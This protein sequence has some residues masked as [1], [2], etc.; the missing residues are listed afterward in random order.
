[1]LPGVSWDKKA[2]DKS[3][4][5]EIDRLN[6]Y[7][8]AQ[9]PYLG[10]DHGLAFDQYFKVFGVWATDSEFNSSV[11]AIQA[12]WEPVYFP[13]AMGAAHALFDEKIRLRIRPYLY[14]EYGVPTG[15]GDSTQLEG[16]PAFLRFGPAL[17]ITLWP[18][19]Y[20][21]AS[22]SLKRLTLVGE[23]KYRWG[24]MGD[25]GSTDYFEAGIDYPLENFR[26]VSIVLKY[27]SGKNDITADKVDQLVL[28]LGLR[29]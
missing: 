16:S 22:P 17:Q 29:F 2:D 14:S 10:R 3:P 25:P 27:T 20:L 9:V 19:E 21:G 5:K 13:L 28:G 11:P 23:Y 1:M 4:S 6:F 24:I 26:D 18:F 12:M 15:A 7:L 8:G